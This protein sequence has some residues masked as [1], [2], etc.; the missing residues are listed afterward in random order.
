MAG[1]DRAPARRTTMLLQ[2]LLADLAA[3]EQ[4]LD[5]VVAALAAPDWLR[6]TPAAG[7][8]IR[9]SLSHICYVDEMATLALTDPDAFETARLARQEELAAGRAG[10][11]ELGRELGEPRALLDRWRTSRAVLLDAAARAEPSLRVP[12]YGPSMG[13]A[14]LVTARLM[15]TWAHGVDILDG[16]TRPLVPT[17]RLRHVCHLG[18]GARAYAFRVHGVDDPGD[19]VGL[20]VRAPDGT[21][22]HWGPDDASDRITGSALDVALVFTQRR[23]HSRTDVVA[24]GRVAQQWLEIAQAFAGPGTVTAV[25]RASSQ[26]ASVSHSRP[27]SSHE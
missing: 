9:D 13:V 4:E 23:H 21:E 27:T 7:W 16:L 19:P 3:E 17:P 8:D 2:D 15:E 25:D 11:V 18:Y 6:P 24:T 14:S 10:D 22:W 26:T 5:T 12:W 1:D 20:S